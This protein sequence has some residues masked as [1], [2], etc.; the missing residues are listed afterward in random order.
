M[1]TILSPREV[2]TLAGIELNAML[3]AEIIPAALFDKGRITSSGTPI[4]DPNG[5][6]LFRRIPI[7]R[8]TASVAF[9]DVAANSSMG[10][11]L[12]AVSYGAAWNDSAIKKQA[13]TSA[14]KHIR[15]MRYDEVRFVAYS[16]PK[17]AV[18]FLYKG[19]EVIMLEWGTWQPVPKAPRRD[20]DMMR[21][22]NFER[23]SL[24]DELPK[25]KRAAND[26]AFMR[27]VDENRQAVSSP[28]LAR[29]DLSKIDLVNSRVFEYRLTTTR[30]VHYTHR[31]RSVDHHPCYE[32]RGQET[33]VWCVAASVQMLLDFYRYEY[34]QTRIA[35][36]LG[37]GTLTNPNGLPY[38]RVAD[39]VTELENLSSNALSATMV[40]NPGW[41]F[42]TNQINAD[43][44][45][46]SFVPGHSRT[47]AG[48]TRTIRIR[49]FAITYQGLLVYDPWPPTTG[50]ITRWENFAAQTYQYGYSADV[51]TI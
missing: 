11:G 14:R 24:L 3:A 5:E 38:S 20:R 18:Q 34:T 44:P 41:T 9:A 1:S 31:S 2:K 32:L 17:I 39:V 45:V 29:L 8:G 13:L 26:R 10:A 25:R 37:L 4:Y 28:T 19:K 21:P 40:T 43:R 47:V 22:S 48:Y 12:L 23:W 35:Q 42:F 46:I 30:E 50:V 36:A 16:Y 27:Q 7:R 49:P 15:Q 6:L 51:A 33:N